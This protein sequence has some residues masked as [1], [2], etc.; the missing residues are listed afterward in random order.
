MKIASQA[1]NFKPSYQYSHEK[2]I[3]NKMQVSHHV[4]KC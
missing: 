2:E 3:M 1:F 4:I